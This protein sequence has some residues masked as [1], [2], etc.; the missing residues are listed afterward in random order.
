MKL[1]R[2]L[3]GTRLAIG[4]AVMVAAVIAVFA[5]ALFG[6]SKSVALTAEITG[7]DWKRVEL[8][9]QLKAALLTNSQLTTQLL[10][11]SDAAEMAK[12]VAELERVRTESQGFVDDLERMLETAESRTRFAQVVKARKEFLDARADVINQA[13]AGNRAEARMSWG[14]EGSPAIK[15]YRK[16]LDEFI[17]QNRAAVDQALA[18]M[19]DDNRKMRLALIAILVA[20]LVSG[21][22][23]A[24]L[25]TRSV[26]RPLS[27]AVQVAEGIAAGHLDNR[28]DVRGA[29]ESAQLMQSL[30]KM[31]LMLSTR[32][33][34][35][36]RVGEEV[37]GIVAAAAAGDFDKRV[38]LTDKQGFFLE[39]GEGMNRLLD[40]TSAG[41]RDLTRVLSALSQGDLTYR[42]D[43]EYHGVFAQMKDDANRT[44]DSLTGILGQIWTTAESI[45]AASKEIAQG[46]A[47]LSCR[48]EQQ[49]GSLEET[50]SSME[51]LT[52]TVRQNA[53]NARQANQL[54]IGA[55]DVAVRGGAVVGQVVSTMGS[56]H[57]SS[58]KIVDIIGVIDGIAFQT[59]ILA[60]NAA[61][62]AARAGEQGRG[63]AVVASEVRNLAQRSAAAAKEIKA[64]IS[65]SVE[66]V[67][68]GAKLVDQAG[69]TM[70][71][72]VGAIKRVTDIVADI[73]AASQEQ[74]GGIE[75]VNQAVTQMDEGTQQNAA[76][77]EE[78]AAAAESLQDQAQALTAAVARFD[79]GRRDAGPMAEGRALAAHAEER[80]QERRGPQRARNVARLN[81]AKEPKRGAPATS[82]V[83]PPPA[84]T[85]T[86][87]EWAE[88]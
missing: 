2:F 64:L 9:N 42:L 43:A 73:S 68:F 58:K 47:D 37:A 69:K 54:A 16:A 17:V 19:N 29:D 7:P 61:V 8:A 11:E 34:A 28:I 38:E 15:A 62:E 20:A 44:V 33:D 45:A 14:V 53:D 26:T 70:E 79:I 85:G 31:Q 3:V 36:R 71:E 23:L 56:I 65:N 24:V 84:R 39:L 30:A 41:M 72:I 63:F 50:A 27:R 51:E 49:A 12:V 76:L 83:Q 52:V 48:T 10:M 55:C 60:L 13:K 82:R 4:F 25:I 6:Q 75:Q 88:F 78:A 67:E 21:V 1:T 35:D 57:E 87:D 18:E 74:S 86:E 5:F 59:N 81:V 22:L 32:A 77:V 46:N 80:P 66:Q 40:T